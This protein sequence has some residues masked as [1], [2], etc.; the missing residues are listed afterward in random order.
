MKILT[1]K[2]ITHKIV[3]III[4]VLLFNFIIPNLSHADS[5]T[6]IGG[7]LFEPIVRLLVDLAD[8]V[9]SFIQQSIFGFNETFIHINRGGDIGSTILGIIAGVVVVAGCIVLAIIT[10]GGSAAPTA[11]LI[12]SIVSGTV[13]GLTWGAITFVG[14]KYITST[15]LPED[16]D[17]PII[18][19]SPE[20]I[21]KRTDTNF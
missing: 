10:A 6:S 13:T 7:M 19:I 8:W 12:T 5:E 9:L 1:N 15:M 21:F 20:S 3:T 17:L 16:F 18:A 4:I 14:A 11:A 2:S